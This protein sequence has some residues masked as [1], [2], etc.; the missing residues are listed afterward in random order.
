MVRRSFLKWATHG[1]GALFGALLGIPALAYL[2]DPRNR[3][4]PAGDFKTVARF[5][6]L[7]QGTP[8]QVVIRGTRH[9]AWTLHPNAVVGRIWLVRRDDQQLDVFTTTCPHLG[10]S[11]NFE[12]DARLFICPCHNGTFELDGR[13]KENTAAANPA[14]RGMDRLEWRRDPANTDLVQ[15]K[16]QNF[17]QGKD[18][19]VPK[20]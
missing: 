11:V 2:I 15:V 10:C 19:P 6:E 13:R 1:L 20:A 4:A 14:P 5:S 16:Y 12:K 7:P 17:Y 9:D 18:V 3:Q 8:T